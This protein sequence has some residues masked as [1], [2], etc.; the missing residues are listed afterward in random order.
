[1]QQQTRRRRFYDLLFVL[2]VQT[3]PNN[4]FTFRLSSA[5]KRVLDNYTEHVSDL[6]VAKGVSLNSNFKV[7]LQPLV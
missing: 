3:L 6:V 1:M 2:E 7:R 4:V 5:K